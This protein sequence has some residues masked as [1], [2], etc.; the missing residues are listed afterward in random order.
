MR[1]Q[2]AEGQQEFFDGPYDSL[3][4]EG[5]GHFVHLERPELF[6]EA[7]KGWCARVRSDANERELPLV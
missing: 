4:V 1:A 7:V 2:V 5:A 6:A 3:L